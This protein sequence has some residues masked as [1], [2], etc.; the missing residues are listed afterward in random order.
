MDGGDG[1]DTMYGNSGNDT[2]T[3]GAGSDTF[4]FATSDGPGVDVI[5]DFN[6]T[7]DTL[8]LSGWGTVGFS[9]TV[10]GLELDLAGG[11]VITLQGLHASDLGEIHIVG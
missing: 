5:K 2:L 6:L 11:E 7:E 10:G 4:S 3:G 8:Q 9:D 1:N